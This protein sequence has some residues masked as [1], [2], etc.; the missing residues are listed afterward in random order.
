[1]A[2]DIATRWSFFHYGKSVMFIIN[3]TS[4][5]TGV[6]SAIWHITASDDKKRIPLI[7][8]LSDSVSDAT[9]ENFQIALNSISNSAAERISISALAVGY[10]DTSSWQ[11]LQRLSTRNRGLAFRLFD[12]TKFVEIIPEKVDGIKKFSRSVLV[13]NFTIVKK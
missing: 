1:M 11:F 9:E 3:L 7:V 2:Y 5:K 8:I 10:T 4:F 12:L 6:Q 13:Y